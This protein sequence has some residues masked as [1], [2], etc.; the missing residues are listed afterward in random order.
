M[1]H[2]R[3]NN[4]A[5]FLFECDIKCFFLSEALPKLGVVEQQ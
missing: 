5:I 2:I 1:K 4:Q 3:H